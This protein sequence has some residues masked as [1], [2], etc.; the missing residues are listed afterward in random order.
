MLL[1]KLIIHLDL[2]KKQL[3]F[4]VN[5]MDSSITFQVETGENIDYR[6]AVVLFDKGNTITL[7][8]FEQWH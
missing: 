8:K 1:L 3:K 2:K 4:Y 5:E 6:L 7:T